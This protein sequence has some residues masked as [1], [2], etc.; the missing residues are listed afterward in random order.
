MPRYII[1][2]GEHTELFEGSLRE[3]QEYIKSMY[4]RSGIV[5]I[6][7][8]VGNKPKRRYWYGKER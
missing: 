2:T 4:E 1:L 7:S 8:E 5:P 3:F 6:W